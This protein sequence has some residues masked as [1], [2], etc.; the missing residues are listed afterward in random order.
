MLTEEQILSIAPSGTEKSRKEY[1]G[2]VDGDF[3]FIQG[4]WLKALENLETLQL[5]RSKLIQENRAYLAPAGRT[6]EAVNQLELE[7]IAQAPISDRDGKKITIADR[8]VWVKQALTKDTRYAEAL[9]RQATTEAQIAEI[10]I[11]INQAER[12]IVFCK[13]QTEYITASLR[14]LGQ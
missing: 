9:Q 3:V 14:F 6:S 10:D 12:R 5:A 4:S 2:R 7:W 8:E 13:L 11:E 1:L